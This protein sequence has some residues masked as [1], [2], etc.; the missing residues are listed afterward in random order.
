LEHTKPISTFVI[1]KDRI[2]SLSEHDGTQDLFEST[3]Q[4]GTTLYKLSTPVKHTALAYSRS[5]D[6]VL[7]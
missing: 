4:H 2:A 6:K 3:L 7:L 1:A 5:D